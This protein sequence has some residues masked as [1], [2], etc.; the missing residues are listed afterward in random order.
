MK[1][2]NVYVFVNGSMGSYSG[3]FKEITGNDYIIAVDGG[4]RHVEKLA[5]KPDVIIGDMDSIRS[6][7]LKKLKLKNIKIIQF[8]KEKD[9]TDLELAL[10]YVIDRDFDRIVVVA[11]LGGRIDHTLTNLLLLTDPRFKGRRVIYFDGV[12][13][14]FLI[15]SAARLECDIGDRISLV[16]ILGKVDGVVTKGLKY[17]LRG[18]TLFPESGRG[19]S[20]EV[21]SKDVEINI[22]SGRLLCIHTLQ[23]KR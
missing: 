23:S 12:A 19:I 13:Y 17:P 2:K 9:E 8:P 11:A 7:D 3:L 15:E 1:K 5:I 18:E 4:Y 10:D 20:N 16:P 14:A 21:I 22:T 6:D